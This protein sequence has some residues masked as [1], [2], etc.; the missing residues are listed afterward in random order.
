[1]SDDGLMDESEQLDPDELGDDVGEQRLPGLESYPPD[2]PLGA[3]DP[4][5][6]ADDDLAVRTL[7]ETRRDTGYEEADEGVDLVRADDDGD[8]IVDDEPRELGEIGVTDDGEPVPPE[9]SAMHIVEE[10]GE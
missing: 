7:R 3:E 2:E 8:S 9:A 6:I 1:M 4:N 10:P 5:L